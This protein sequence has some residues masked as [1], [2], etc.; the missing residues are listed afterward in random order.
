MGTARQSHPRTAPQA[1]AHACGRQCRVR[2]TMST[3]EWRRA[4]Q[5]GFKAAHVGGKARQE[6]RRRCFRISPHEGF[7]GVRPCGRGRELL[8]CC[9]DVQNGSRRGPAVNSEMAGDSGGAREGRPRQSRIFRVA[10]ALPPVPLRLDTTGS[11]TFRVST[12]SLTR[13]H[14]RKIGRASCRERV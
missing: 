14:A 3:S 8:L 11:L 12:G 10:P 6:F 9:Y 1:P 2:G 4:A 7:K 5:G 13:S